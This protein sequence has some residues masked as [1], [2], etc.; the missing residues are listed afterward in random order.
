MKKLI[1]LSGFIYCLSLQAQIRNNEVYEETE[2]NNFIVRT[3]IRIPGFSGYQTLKCD[4]HT[5]TVFSDG[6]VWPN[7]RV[8]EAW[9]QGLDAVAITDHI[10][11]RPHKEKI[12]GDLNESYN[13]A[14]KTGDAIGFI[15]IKGA[16]I[17]RKKPLG[18][19]NAL[20]LKDA[21]PLDVDNPLDAIDEAKRQGAFVMWN[22]PGWPDDK[23]TLYPVHE[24]LIKDKKIDGIETFNHMEYYPVAFDWCRDMNLAVMGNSDIHDLVS[25]EYGNLIRPFT[26][27][28]AREKSEEAIREALF[29]GRT[30]AY[31]NGQLAGK[32]EYLQ[33]LLL[34]SV[35][36]RHVSGNGYEVMNLSDIPYRMT[37][38][39]KLFILPA[40]KTI[41]MRSPK[42]ETFTIENCYVGST[43]KLTVS[44]KA[45]LESK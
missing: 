16:E 21:N 9:Q 24:Q 43:E 7:V 5:H 40:G 19:L 10:E 11:Y 3:E 38:D 34:A 23:S 28:F 35:R 13:I 4:F 2:M 14:R 26:L 20:F 39:G 44:V 29:A 6:N 18:H 37:A 36:V 22:H 25:S 32:A 41:G 45:F 15:V 31:F 17:T 42:S 12:N 27:V 30:A 1:L 33:A 8:T